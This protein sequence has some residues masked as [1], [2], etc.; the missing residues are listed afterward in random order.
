MN[1]QFY[2]D[3]QTV[4][5]KFESNCKDF[6]FARDIDKKDTLERLQAQ[7][8]NLQLEQTSPSPYTYGPSGR[9]QPGKILMDIEF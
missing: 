4:L 5:F 9:I 3:F 1:V 2:N 8:S 6:A 7:I